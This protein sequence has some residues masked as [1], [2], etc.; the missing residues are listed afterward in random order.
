MKFINIQNKLNNRN[1]ENKENK[2]SLIPIPF[3]C[4]KNMI[5][6]NIMFMKS[7]IILECD[8]EQEES[9]IQLLTTGYY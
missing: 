7:N 3:G 4:D 6:N 2:Y 1:F 8:Y 9:D 5:F